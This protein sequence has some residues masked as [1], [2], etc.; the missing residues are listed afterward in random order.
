[1]ISIENIL[2]DMDGVLINSL[3]EIE[4]FWISLTKKYNISISEDMIAKYIHGLK[5][6]QTIKSLFNELS[7]EQ[8]EDIYISAKNFDL[9][10]KPLPIDGVFEFIQV[11]KKRNIPIGLVT[12]SNIERV[13]KILGSLN[14][15][16]FFNYTISENDTNIG[17]PN[18]MPYLL[19]SEK[20]GTSPKNTLVFEDSLSG[21]KSAIEAGMNVIAIN[22]GF[23]SDKIYALGVKILT[24]NFITL[25][26]SHKNEIIIENC[27]RLIGADST[28]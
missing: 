25:N 16:H 12:S 9:D 5:T 4:N 28:K 15:F 22:N 21:I 8:K 23:E 13:E 7:N 27:Y 1:M 20:T 19:M 2:F 6:N 17:K 3:N 24:K 14:M 10:M 26:Y 18:P 11:L